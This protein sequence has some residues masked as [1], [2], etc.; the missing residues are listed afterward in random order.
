[1]NID[2]ERLEKLRIVSLFLPLIEM[3]YKISEINGVV[4]KISFKTHKDYFDYYR[5]SF[6]VLREGLTEYQDEPWAWYELKSKVIHNEWFAKWYYKKM[7][8]KYGIE[9]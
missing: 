4:S 5:I 7:L 3:E 6:S 2:K 9:T 8:K 1:M